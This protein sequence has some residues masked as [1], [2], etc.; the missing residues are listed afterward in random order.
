MWDGISLA[1]LTEAAAGREHWSLDPRWETA[2]AGR[3]L[4]EAGVTAGRLVPAGLLRHRA[5][6]VH[7]AVLATLAGHDEASWSRGGQDGIGALAQRAWT[8]PGQP[9]FW[10]AAIHLRQLPPGGDLCS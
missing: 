8:V 6:R 5:A 7:D 2:Q 3:T 9:A 10:H 4:N 1:V